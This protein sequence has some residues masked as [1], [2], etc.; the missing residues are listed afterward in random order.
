MHSYL[1]A[2]KFGPSHP[3]PNSPSEFWGKQVGVGFAATRFL[4]RLQTFS[5]LSTDFEKAVVVLL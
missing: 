4:H 3:P 2:V 1:P 5:G